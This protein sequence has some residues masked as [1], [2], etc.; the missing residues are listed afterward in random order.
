MIVFDALDYEQT[1]LN[2]YPNFDWECRLIDKNVSK[3]GNFNIFGNESV[4][5][6][7]ATEPMIIEVKNQS[8]VKVFQNLFD[9][10]WDSGKDMKR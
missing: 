2:N 3:E 5:L 8:L 7:S 6:H 4:V 1:F 10:L 9:I